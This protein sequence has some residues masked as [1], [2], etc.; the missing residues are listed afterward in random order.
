VFETILRELAARFDRVVIDS[1]P[2]VPVTDAAIVAT[3]TDGVVLVVR[4]FGTAKQLARQGTRTLRHVGG[5]I[6][7]CVLNAVDVTKTDYKHY[8]YAYYRRS[9]YYYSDAESAQ[10]NRGNGANEATR[11]AS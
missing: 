9:G 1:P 4:A 3:R 5:R 6:A 8:Y 7:G 2:I 11:A 10:A